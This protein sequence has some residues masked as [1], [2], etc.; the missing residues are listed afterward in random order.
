VGTGSSRCFRV[1][2]S[3]LAGTGEIEGDLTHAAALAAPGGRIDTLTLIGIF[4]QSHPGR[5]ASI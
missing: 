1:A 2:G 5:R 4:R 3:T